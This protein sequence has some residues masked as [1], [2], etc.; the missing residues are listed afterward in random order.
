M[1]NTERIAEYIAKGCTSK[2]QIGVE[3]EH[4]A[5]KE[6]LSQVSYSGGIRGILNELSEY[7]PEKEYSLGEIIALYDNEASITIEP[8]GQIEISIKPCCSIE[9][10]DKIYKKFLS[11]AEPILSSR[12]MKLVN[13][14]YTPRSKANDE[15][16]IP[17]TRYE[18]MDRYFNNTGS[19]GRN[20]M[21]ATASTQVSIDFSDESDCVNKLRA[22]NLLTP[23]FSLITDNSPFFEG[24]RYSG[25]MLR[26]KIWQSV[27]NA[28]CGTV[29][30]LFADRF[31]FLKYAEYVYN[32]P[33]I[34]ILTEKGAVYTGSRPAS[35]IYKGREL[36]DSEIEHLL[37]MFFPDTRLKR[38]IEIRPADSMPHG[39]AM[40]Y[41]ALIKAIFVKGALPELPEANENDIELAKEELLK[42]GFDGIIYGH[43][44]KKII[45]D[46]FEKAEAVLGSKDLQY[47][48]PLA[49][50]A[51][52]GRTIYEES[53]RKGIFSNELSAGI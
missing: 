42:N 33:P 39:F 9:D 45:N 16:L 32:S 11:R 37:S 21:R 28:R 47:L 48:T 30:G 14:G 10:I 49:S 19:M 22:A 40:G 41:A 46:M 23:I 50:A 13:L 44:V 20:M 18:F 3:I 17:K 36:H 4:F 53:T 27:D 31:G 8:A 12:G 52:S 25:R 35:D 43:P 29:P 34:L 24:N 51:R 1:T 26:T 7:Y 5:V 38:Y 15:E 2:K 6:D